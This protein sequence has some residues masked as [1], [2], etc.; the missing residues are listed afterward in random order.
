MRSPLVLLLLAL[1][2][3]SACQPLPSGSAW[4]VES[5]R[6]LDPLDAPTPSTELLALYVRWRSSDLE[7]RLDFLDLPLRPTD[8]LALEIETKTGTVRLT[9]PAEGRPLVSPTDAPFRPRLVRD[10]WL[11]T[12]V[13]RLNRLA[14]GSPFVLRA[15]TFRPGQ[16]SPADSLGPVRSDALPPQARAPVLLVFS[17]V[18]P[19]YTPAQALRRW[20]GAHTGPR[21]GRHG[22]KILLDAAQAHR[23]PLVLL[24]ARQPASLAALEYVGALGRLRTLNE[25]GLLILPEVAYSQPAER[26]LTFSRLAGRGFSLPD[27]PFVYAASAELL[28]RYQLQFVPLTDTRHLA[29]W[30]ALRLA[31]LPTDEVAQ[32]DENGLSL[33]MRR[34][35]VETL[36][37]DDPASLTVLGGRLPAS[38]FGDIELGPQALAW[39]AAHPWIWV[40]DGY[41]LLTFPAPVRLEGGEVAWSAPSRWQVALEGAPANALT[42][43]AWLT[44]LQLN[45]PV[46]DP[47]LADLQRAYIGQVGILLEAARWAEAPSL[48]LDCA[49][50][51]DDDGQPEC[52]LADR[53]L[54]AVIE[55]GGARLTHLFLLGEDGP[56]Q[57]VA[58]T[59]QFIVG[60]SDRSQW[61]PQA[62]EAADPGMLA[63]AFAEMGK[64][65]APFSVEQMET[66]TLTLRREDGL[67]KTF[68][69]TEG[70]VQVSYENAR[71]VTTRL[72]LLIDP[73]RFYFAPQEFWP[74][75]T[76]GQVWVWGGEDGWRV[77]VRTDAFLTAGGV[78]LSRRFMSVPEDP[79]FD[80]PREHF[81]PF[82]FSLVQVQ[83]QGEFSIWLEGVPPAARP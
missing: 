72:P 38:L 1:L 75:L 54:F 58:P 78:N 7:I 35:L 70:G 29:R 80:F 18:F 13:V 74:R 26:S 51:P 20:N 5:L 67:R 76:P 48:R 82:P 34:R 57:L 12:V 16:D 33:A 59:A 19:A 46:S 45:R 21:G 3:F 79:N 56:H 40:L 65:F 55:R 2:L 64:E 50:D 41:D 52:L 39:L 60:L 9:F 47:A 43:A 42:D 81:L 17:D 25:R 36:F 15:F 24:D 4:K 27:S 49:A 71:F 32:V 83:G 14:L 37:D 61:R 44:F 30:G 11:D 10:P 31:P 63:G 68:R 73:W 6:L 77:Q 23:L 69:L 62:G 53:R 22:L 66:G 28:P 8:D